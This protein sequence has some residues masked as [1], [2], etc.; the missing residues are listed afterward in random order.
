[1][2]KKKKYLIEFIT[3][4]MIMSLVIIIVLIFLS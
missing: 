1:M 3:L 4:L 2:I